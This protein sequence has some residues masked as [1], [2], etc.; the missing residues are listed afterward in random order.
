MA[1]KSTIPARAGLAGKSR[2]AVNGN[3]RGGAGAWLRLSEKAAGSARPGPVAGKKRLSADDFMERPV[4]KRRVSSFPCAWVAIF[5]AL[6]DGPAV[7][8]TTNCLIER[9]L[10]FPAAL[11]ARR[12]HAMVLA[13]LS[14]QMQLARR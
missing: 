12:W 11:S 8:Q 13:N 5:C 4:V 7:A 6:L 3:G 2:R 1:G 9:T 10:Q 14:A